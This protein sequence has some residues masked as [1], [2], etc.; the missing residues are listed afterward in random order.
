MQMFNRCRNGRRWIGK[1]DGCALAWAGWM[2]LW[3]IGLPVAGAD[4]AAGRQ[5][6]L[7]GNYS[8][9]VR[10][11]EQALRENEPGESWRLLLAD[12]YLTIGKYP[13]AQAVM[14]S[15]VDRYATSLRTRWLSYQVLQQCNQPTQAEKLLDELILLANMRPNA[16]R[17]A[18]SLV[19]IGKA[20]LLRGGEP[21]LVLERLFDQAKTVDPDCREAYLACGDLALEKHDY[22]LAARNFR[23]GL[24]RFPKDP[25]FHGGL[26]KAYA[27]S[28]R[29]EMATSVAAAL[30]LNPHHIPSLLLLA[31][32][33]IDSEDYA[34]ADQ[35]LAKVLAIN[36]WHS[37]AWAYRA[38]IKHLNNDGP[39]ET[40]ARSTALRYG[41]T[42]P[43]VD[44]LIGTKLSQKYRFAE[45]SAYQR[46]ALQLD[47]RFWPSAI[48][49]AQDLLRLGEETEGWRLAEAVHQ[50]DGYD[51]VAYNLVTLKESLAKFQTV[52]NRDFIVRLSSREASIYGDRVLD[53]LSRA[54]AKL[55]EKYEL[56]LD[57]P[58]VVEIFPESKDF[59]VRTFGMPGDSSYLGVC[60]GRVITANSPA[61]QTAHPMNWQ[62]MLW[63][64]FAHVITLQ[65]TRNRMPRWLSEGISVYEERQ[66]NPAWGLHMN[67]RYREMILGDE[68]TPISKLSAA[69]LSPKD[70]QHLDFA[71]YES[72]LAVE[73]LVERFGLGA[74]KNVL[75]ELGR[76][77]NLDQ[78]VEKHIPPLKE[79]DKDFA[80]YARERAQKLG[81]GLEWG[82][83]PT[84]LFADESEASLD[85]WIQEHPT[86]YWA[87]TERAKKLFEAKQYEAAKVPLNKLIEACPENTGSDNA[88]LMLAE[89][90]RAL[91]EPELERKAL[92]Q[93]ATLDAGAVEVFL[94]LM[95]LSVSAQD[96]TTVFEN[97]ERYL[98]VNPLV[99]T[100]YRY[101]AQACEHLDQPEPAIQSYRL[102]LTLDP[103]DPAEV[104]YRLARLLRNT[105]DPAAKRHVLQALEEAPRYRDAYQVL[106]EINR[107]AH[108]T[109]QTAKP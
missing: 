44:C 32:H 5:E 68:L 83:P 17:D 2:G 77:A 84:R 6:F 57:A 48:Q 78:A 76:G 9:C 33:M 15:A 97:A 12:A 50:N 94:R 64:E 31:D 99:A 107:E 93:L 91:N 3:L 24:Q 92:A 21:R 80:A 37:E 49:R 69:F 65:L 29:P 86:N 8:N 18:T 40:E 87:L 27:S 72:S 104:H 59:A 4:L 67:A 89:T 108:L 45:G 103:P 90:H 42:N 61:T 47:P 81:P 55:S 30:Q 75:I 22:E 82:K 95:E 10:L 7:S 73:F 43:K 1:L 20:A 98:A 88:Y 58:V 101:R 53:L 60:F 62:A 41:K 26:A 39:G 38:V 19:V 34:E 102:L 70:L 46:Q 74:L 63:H 109:P 66:A 16:Y 54:K 100:P 96:W 85:P 56:K 52:T 25:D 23:L 35:T 105:G 36:P 13:E 51:V 28:S 11:C 14:A 79:M 106:L 71:Y